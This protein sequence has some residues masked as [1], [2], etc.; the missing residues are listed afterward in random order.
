LIRKTAQNLQLAIL[1]KQTYCR[2]R[3]AIKSIR[4][5]HSIMYHILKY[6]FFTY[7]QPVIKCP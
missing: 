2:M 4:F 3:N 7:C 5:Y 6:H 1:M